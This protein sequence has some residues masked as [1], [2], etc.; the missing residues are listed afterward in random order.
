MPPK[1]DEEVQNYCEHVKP[2]DCQL[3]GHHLD[4]IQKPHTIRL[5]FL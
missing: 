2:I 5:I 1:Y 3:A 4:A